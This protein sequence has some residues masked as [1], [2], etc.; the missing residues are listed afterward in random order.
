MTSEAL[1]DSSS[2][3]MDNSLRLTFGPPVLTVYTDIIIVLL[4]TL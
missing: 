1:A 2:N 3:D 4:A